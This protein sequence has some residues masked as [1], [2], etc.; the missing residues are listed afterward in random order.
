MNLQIIDSI[1]Y[2]VQP[3]RRPHNC[4]SVLKSKVLTETPRIQM[5]AFFIKDPT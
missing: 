2:Y 4:I 3:E 5:P 1:K